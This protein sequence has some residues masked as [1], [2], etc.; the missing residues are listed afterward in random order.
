MPRA[1]VA[2]GTSLAFANRSAALRCRCIVSHCDTILCRCRS[3]RILYLAVADLCAALPGRCVALRCRCI[4]SHCDTILCRCRSS[5]TLY[6]AVALRC[7]ALPL[8]CDALPCRC[9]ALHSTPCRCR[10]GHHLASP[11]PRV[12]VRIVSILCR[13]FASRCRQCPDEPRRCSAL[14]RTAVA[15]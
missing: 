2:R 7:D 13:C 5:R 15:S 12:S 10:S 6:L 11:L 1:N 3:S 14:R 4:V 9:V 8:P